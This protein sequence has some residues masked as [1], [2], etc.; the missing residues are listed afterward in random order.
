MIFRSKIKN[1]KPRL[2]LKLFFIIVPFFLITISIYPQS[3]GNLRG[4]VFDKASGDGLPGA[5]VYLQ[6][7]AIGAASDYQG[8]YIISNILIGT[9]NIVF[10]YVGYEKRIVKVEI[11]PNQT[12]VLNVSLHWDS[13]ATSKEV[14]VV[15]QLE[16]QAQ[17]INQQISS[18]RIVNVVSQQKI[19]ELP[20]A[21]AA[22]AIGRLPGV[23]VQREGGEADKLM[24][25]GLDPR[26]TTVTMNG[27]QIPGTDF[28]DRSIDLSLISQSS[29]AG[30]E[31]YKAVTA[32]QDA[33]AIAGTVNLITG[34]AK[35]GQKISVS[36]YGIYNG[37]TK[38]SKQYRGVIQF[39][40][41]FISDRLG[42]QAELSAE[43]RDRTDER[44]NQS[45]NIPANGNYTINALVPEL[46]SE[47]RKR[48]NVNINL[49][50][51]TN[52][53]GNIKFLN[54]F[55][56]TTRDI[57]TSSRDFNTGASY[58][59]YIGEA[60][61]IY[62]QTFN[63]SLVGENH[64]GDFKVNWALS[65]A[66]TQDQKPFDH[67]MRF[68]E[69]ET[70]YSGMKIIT[71]PNVLKEPGVN[72]I[73]YAWN[74]FS[75]ADLDRCFFYQ[76]ESSE[77]NY[78]VKLD[79]E[80]PIRVN[81]TFDGLIQFGYKLRDKIRHRNGDESMTAYWLRTSYNTTM[82]NG[83]IVNKDWT[84]SDWPNAYTGKLTDYLE[85]PPYKTLVINNQYLL[86]P[87]LSEKLVRDWYNFNKN[88]ISADGSSPEYIPQLTGLNDFYNVNENI[89]GAYLMTKI[90]AGRIISLI[91]GA[92]VEYENNFYNAYFVP[93]IIG[94]F[95]QTA[96]VK[97]DTT[98]QFK[99]TQLFPNVHLKI[100]PFDW[101]NVMLAVTKTIA[102]PDFSMRLPSLTV[103]SPDRQI[104]ATNSNLQPAISWNYDIS[105]S[106]YTSMYGLLTIDGFRKDINNMF[107]WLNGIILLNDQQARNMGLPVDLYGPWN[108]YTVNMPYNT[109]NTK[110]SGFEIDLQT[111][112]S[113]L[114]GV[115]KNIVISTNYTRIWS[116]T[117]YPRF[118]LIQSN[119]FPPQPPKPLFYN[120][121]NNLTGQTNYIE[122]FSIGYDYKGF[123]GRLSAY[124]QGPYLNSINNLPYLDVYQKAFSRW[125]I[126]LK[127][128]ILDNYQVFL[129]VNNLSNT[130]EGS[131]AVFHSL[132][133]GGYLYGIDLELGVRVTLE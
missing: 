38:N 55:D 107:Y 64:L 68:Y 85:G 40:N 27:V 62:I 81:N 125:D 128:S 131:Y 8:N 35:A 114:P 46:N 33:D 31:L 126:S 9:H 43:S 75:V 12:L 92:R 34:Q 69:N 110:V 3:S 102:R 101:W 54:S 113:F 47:T 72:L 57:F 52:D 6:G 36:L 89:N 26:F 41:R 118:T 132:D 29:L 15:G 87:V 82:D 49:D 65:H 80:Y 63:N 21:N 56:R 108:Q 94:E 76:E 11:E 97:I 129:N 109:S 61:D 73:P 104:Y 115:L 79:I 127:Q 120:T 60:Q 93:K 123:S 84:A 39:S 122:N 20:D 90:N 66:Y 10:S 22:E 112:L 133:M 18:D 59:T 45:W 51:N 116:S 37:I 2:Y 44:W 83:V 30:I 23:A 103:D 13:T 1:S 78:E 53:G 16:G 50:Y 95:T 74:N 99:Q 100:K 91:A 105:T 32:D 42:V 5:N 67:W 121:K 58:V 19:Q 111:H 48:Y 24:V 71:D 98:T 86:N 7:T 25:R 96:P 28:D 119:T 124:F 88:G 77:R 4:K 70:T 106:F 130:I 17:A 14:V 117:E